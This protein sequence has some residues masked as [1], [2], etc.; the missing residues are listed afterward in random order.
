MSA[1]V[2]LL[3]LGLIQIDHVNVLSAMALPDV[4]VDVAALLHPRR[5]VRALDL[6]LLSAL[7][8]RV[9]L[10]VPRVDVAL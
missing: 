1:Q 5:A 7:E 2:S 3:C 10:E 6:R 9:P 4:S 8:L